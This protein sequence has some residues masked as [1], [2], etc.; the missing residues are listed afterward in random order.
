MFHLIQYFPDIVQVGTIALPQIHRLGP[1]CL[2]FSGRTQARQ[3]FPQSVVDD[4]LH[5]GVSRFPYLFEQYGNIGIEAERRPHTSKH[6]MIDALMSALGSRVWSQTRSA[7]VWFQTSRW[8]RG[9][10]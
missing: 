4:L 8:R 6:N 5:S 1:K 2:G 3:T 10:T 7:L 9:G